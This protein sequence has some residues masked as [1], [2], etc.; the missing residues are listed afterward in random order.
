MQKPVLRSI[1]ALPARRSALAKLHRFGTLLREVDERLPHFLVQLTAGGVAR[2]VEDRHVGQLEVG[3]QPEPGQHRQALEEFVQMAGDD[4]LG[5]LPPR[6]DSGVARR[7]SLR[8][9]HQDSLTTSRSR[10]SVAATV[11]MRLRAPHRRGTTP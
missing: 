3:P 10:S 4:G 7:F 11:R 8:N 6:F 2:P 9:S 1:S 5:V